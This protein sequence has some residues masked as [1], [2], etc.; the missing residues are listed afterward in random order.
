MNQNNIKPKTKLEGTKYVK[1]FNTGKQLHNCKNIL[2]I[3]IL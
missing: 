3:Y 2:S 1:P